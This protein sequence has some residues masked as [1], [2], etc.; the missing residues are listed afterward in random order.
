MEE[1]EQLTPL[2][3]VMADSKKN[4]QGFSPEEAIVAFA[5]LIQQKNAKTYMEGN[6]IMVLLDEGN[7]RGEFHWVN[8][9]RLA[10][11]ARSA[12]IV[13]QRVADEGYKEIYTEFT[14][15]KILQGLE[16]VPFPYTVEERDN[17]ETQEVEYIATLR[18]QNGVG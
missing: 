15:P 12:T 7:G 3:I 8:A 10:D 1:R 9:D 18:L 5:E 4:P 13:F 14:N 17:P 11:F 16:R 2:Q 6:S